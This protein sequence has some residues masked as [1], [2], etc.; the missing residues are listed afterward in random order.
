[1][2]LQIPQIKGIKFSSFFVEQIDASL[3]ISDVTAQGFGVVTLKVKRKFTYPEVKL[4]ST[5]A[6]KLLISVILH[7]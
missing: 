7:C 2:A 1:L 6:S 5:T 4:A 3:Q